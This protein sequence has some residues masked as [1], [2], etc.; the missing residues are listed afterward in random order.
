MAR[1][2]DLARKI[3]HR[4]PPLCAVEVPR[5]DRVCSDGGH[6]VHSDVRLRRHTIVCGRR[7][8]L[9][10]ICSG[11]TLKSRRAS[12]VT[13]GRWVVADVTRKRSGSHDWIFRRLTAFEFSGAT[14]PGC[15]AEAQMVDA[16]RESVAELTRVASAATRG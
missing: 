13:A 4:A 3:A 12:P 5:S 6:T 10:V 2:A 16:R 15:G 1:T 11:R 7:L 14:R 9:E 8:G